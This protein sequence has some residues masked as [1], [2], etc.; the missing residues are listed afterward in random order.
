MAPSRRTLTLSP[1]QRDELVWHRDH[2]PKPYI[3]ERAAALLKVADGASPNGVARQGLFKRRDPDTVYTWLNWFQAEGLAGLQKHPQGGFRG[4][5][6]ESHRDEVRDRLHHPP[7][8]LVDRM[9]KRNPALAP[10][11]YSLI[12]VQQ[13]FAWLR[14]YSVSGVWRVLQRLDVTWK[15]GYVEQWSPD[16]DY[17]TKVQHIEDCLHEAVTD[18]HHVVVLFLDEMGYYRWPTAAHD[19]GAKFE[20]SPLVEHGHI[21]NQQWR[22]IAALN[23]RTG[24]VSYLQ[25]YIIGRAKVIEFYAMLNRIYRHAKKVYVIEDNWNVHS[26]PEVRAALA[27]LP[28]LEIV[29]LPTYAPWLNPI[30]KLWRWLRQR[31]LHHH[32]MSDQWVELQGRVAAF[33]DQ[34]RHGSHELLRYVG[35]LGDGKFARALGSDYRI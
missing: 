3:R 9:A 11:R 19:W 2:D 7:S 32:R 29:P 10:C 21:N 30:E 33:F 22:V 23:V 13:T 1:K 28:R 4:T 25:S 17:A 35:L 34:F 15:H 18:P 14:D 26:L 16:P 12:V 5:S 24:Q 27:N 20:G 8:A 31:I 6:L